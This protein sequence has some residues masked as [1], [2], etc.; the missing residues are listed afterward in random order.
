MFEKNLNLFK[1]VWAYKLFFTP[2]VHLSRVY[3]IFFLLKRN[4]IKTNQF[5]FKR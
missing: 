4:G 1:D 5:N 3:D 2:V